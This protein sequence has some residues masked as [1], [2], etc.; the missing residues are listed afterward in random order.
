MCDAAGEF[1]VGASDLRLGEIAGAPFWMSASRF[2]YWRHT[3]L[4]T[5]VVPGRGN[6]FSLETP[7]GARFLTHSRVFSADEE[8]ELGAAG[9]PVSGAAR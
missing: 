6:G 8:K 3:H 7:K 4:I 5:D 2:A 9:E 1:H